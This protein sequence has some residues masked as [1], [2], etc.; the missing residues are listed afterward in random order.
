MGGKRARGDS[1]FGRLPTEQV[2]PD[3]LELDRMSAD[4]LLS[5]MADE[6]ALVA[7][8][9]RREAPRIQKAAG[10]MAAALAGGGRVFY[11]GAGTSGRLGVLE[12]AECPPTYG[13][14]PEAI[15]GIMAGG[16]RSVFRS[17][18]GAEDDAA[19][20][21]REMQEHGVAPTD[22]VIGISASSVTPFVRGAVTAAR[23]S[24]AA[25]ALVTCGPRVRGLVDVVIAAD[26]GPELLAGSTRMKAG[27]AQKLILNQVTLLAMTRLKKVYGPYMVDLRATS[28]KLRDRAVRIVMTLVDCERVRAEEL[29][30]ASG[31][32]VKTA[33]VM[34]RLELD[35]ATAK[36]RLAAAGHDLRR[37]LERSAKG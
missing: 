24:G 5:R 8:A 3:G 31:K 27:T 25:T 33:V 10:R 36:E 29:F 34:G 32:D 16:S 28:A 2:H 30:R 22:L 11:V 7:E 37:V 20:G 9:V 15:V 18:E 6:D 23:S 21:A 4:A 13:T 12:A 1:P 19:A 35:A 17:R 14:R 26:V